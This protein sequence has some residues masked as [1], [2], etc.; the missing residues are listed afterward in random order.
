M[1]HVSQVFFLK[2]LMCII[3]FCIIHWKYI[4]VLQF[5]ISESKK[6]Y[7]Q[8]RNCTAFLKKRK[9][10]KN[11]LLLHFN[12]FPVHF[13]HGITN[14]M[15]HPRNY[16]STTRMMCG[17]TL[18]GWP[19][20]DL[21][22]DPKW[23]WGHTLPRVQQVLVHILISDQRE[24]GEHSQQVCNHTRLRHL[25]ILPL[26]R[27]TIQRDTDRPEERTH[28]DFVKFNRKKHDVLP[29]ERS[30]RMQH[31]LG[32]GWVCREGAQYMFSPIY[33]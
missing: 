3:F 25:L 11:I 14:H 9:K 10:Q 31:R 28:R 4:S 18:A 1:L 29:Q 23:L 30:S 24:D 32:T 33:K 6:F 26:L 21:G 7:M 27:V 13:L 5:R 20:S 15:L 8:W 12:C 17:T 22:Y 2:Q 19:C 16:T